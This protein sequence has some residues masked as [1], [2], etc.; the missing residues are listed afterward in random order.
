MQCVRLFFIGLIFT[1]IQL[2]STF[3]ADKEFDSE[4]ILSDLE[5]QLELSNE[6]LSS[7]KPAI[8][9][10]GVELKKSIHESVDKG[11]IQLD[12]LSQKLENISRDVEKKAGEILNSE[13]MNKLKNYLSKIDKKAVSEMKDKAVADL[14]DVLELTEEQLVKLKP[15]IEDGFTQMEKMFDDLAKEGNKSWEGFKEQYEEL[16]EELQGKMQDTLDDE[17]MKR[18]EKYN[19]EKKVKLQK[20]FY[21]V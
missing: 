6:Q 4:Q 21:S 3:A 12:K 15:V 13:E 18:L 8:D 14:S 2:S 19:E 20:A 7:L 5:K 17:Q 11:F 16:R 9:A 1:T 10:K